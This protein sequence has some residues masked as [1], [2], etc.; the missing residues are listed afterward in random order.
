MIWTKV[1]KSKAISQDKSETMEPKESDTDPEP[2]NW[3]DLWWYTT[4]FF[5]GISFSIS[6]EIIAS[7]SEKKRKA[8][9]VTLENY[10]T[11]KQKNIFYLTALPQTLVK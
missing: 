6:G 5:S 1:T 4:I 3:D 11:V 10:H 8:A 2:E 7:I 9:T